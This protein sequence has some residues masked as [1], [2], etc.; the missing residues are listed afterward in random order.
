MFVIFSLHTFVF[1]RDTVKIIIIKIIYFKD[2]D[3]VKII[4]IMFVILIKKF[5][6]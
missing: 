6:W 3:S 4:K 2:N 1:I 5:I